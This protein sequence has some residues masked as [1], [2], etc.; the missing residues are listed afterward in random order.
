VPE[1]QDYLALTNLQTQLQ[2]MSVDGGY[3]YDIPA[4]AVRFDLDH[5]VEDLIAPDGPRPFVIIE[6]FVEE[7]W[8]LVEK[9]NGLRLVKPVRIHWVDDFSPTADAA[10]LLKFLRGCADV[11][12]A[13]VPD[14]SRGGYASNTIITN[15]T[16]NEEANPLM[17]WAFIDASI[18]IRRTYG[19]PDV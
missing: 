17:V 10:K 4:G 11:E 15:R 16:F 5:D 3:H 8:E 1:P 9:P 2:A 13:I 14:P 7:R 12:R 6:A 18:T 19:E